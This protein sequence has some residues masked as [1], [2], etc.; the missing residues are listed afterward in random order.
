M[1]EPC[2]AQ[3]GEGYGACDDDGPHRR[4]AA[5]PAPGAGDQVAVHRK[6]DRPEPLVED[7]DVHLV[8][9]VVGFRCSSPPWF[10]SSGPD[11]EPFSFSVFTSRKKSPPL[12]FPLKP[13]EYK[14]FLVRFRNFIVPHKSPPGF[15][16]IHREKPQ[17]KITLLLSIPTKR[18]LA[19][20]NLRVERDF[21][22]LPKDRSPVIYRLQREREAANKPS[23]RF[24]MCGRLR[25]G[26]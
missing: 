19:P 14:R 23:T 1:S 10:D 16:A 13:G 22:V 7:A 9:A 17:L 8:E 6:G 18:T 25:T 20:K 5:P 21:I 12:S 11:P 2:C 3:R 24:P 15:C 26:K 4:E